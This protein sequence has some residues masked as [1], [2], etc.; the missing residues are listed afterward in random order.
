MQVRD[1]CKTDLW[2]I[3]IDGWTRYRQ[4]IEKTTYWAKY[5]DHLP[6]SVG[7]EIMDTSEI[8]EQPEQKTDVNHLT[9][10]HFT[11]SSIIITLTL[12]P[13]HVH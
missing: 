6:V 10:Q 7:E 9:R 8:I 12:F 5:T 13:S 2:P 1:L 11:I 3:Y 4:L